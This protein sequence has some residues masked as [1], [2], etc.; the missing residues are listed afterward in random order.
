VICRILNE[1]LPVLIFNAATPKSNGGVKKF[2][3]ELIKGLKS[4]KLL[5]YDLVGRLQE[6]TVINFTSF[7]KLYFKYLR[8]VEVVHFIVLSP[9][10]IPFAIMAK[11]F[12][13]KIITSYHGI[14][15]QESSFL[16]EPQIFISFWIADK[17]FRSCSDM[18]TSPSEYLIHEL[19]INQKAN[20]K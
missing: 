11:I 20:I 13:K 6:G 8:S 12:K 1:Y 3:M 4:K 19:K 14:Y 7:L 10:N 15:F 9:Y 2:A 16:K 18:I 17:I 5:V